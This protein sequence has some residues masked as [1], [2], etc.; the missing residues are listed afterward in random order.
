MAGDVVG[1]VGGG[2]HGALRVDGLEGERDVPLQGYAPAD[3]VDALRQRVC[4]WRCSCEPVR[5]VLPLLSFVQIGVDA[6]AQV[7]V[8]P[9]EVRARDAGT[10]TQSAAATRA[11][12]SRAAQHRTRSPSTHVVSAL[13]GGRSTAYCTPADLRAAFPVAL[14]AIF[15]DSTTTSP[16]AEVQA[17]DCLRAPPDGWQREPPRSRRGRRCCRGRTTPRTRLALEPKPPMSCASF[18]A[19]LSLRLAISRAFCRAASVIL[20]DRRRAAFGALGAHEEHL[21]LGDG[22]EDGVALLLQLRLRHLELALERLELR[23]EAL[24]LLGVAQRR[25]HHRL[26]LL[27]HEL[28]LLRRV[29]VPPH[30]ARLLQPLHLQRLRAVRLLQLGSAACSCSCV[31][32]AACSCATWWPSWS[33]RRRSSG[34]RRRA[35]HPVAPLQLGQVDV[36]RVDV[37][38]VRRDLLDHALA[39][40]HR[41]PQRLQ[42]GVEHLVE[43]PLLHQ[44][45][46][47]ARRAGQPVDLRLPLHQPRRARRRRDVHRHLHRPPAPRPSAAARARAPALGRGAAAAEPPSSA[48]GG[49]L[50]QRGR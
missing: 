31:P 5:L 49:S 3:E 24:R 8:L 25:L 29:A 18:S 9:K 21:L 37:R 45:L 20:L 42:L 35:E 33:I 16:V 38:R 30:L 27:D 47:A 43:L 34:R 13:L 36:R 7:L 12:C 48:A 4:T 26:E 14:K 28:L 32:S 6:R 46:A 15:N 22:G 2:D 17:G 50:P 41:L 44:L 23:L 11:S 39:R 1:A 10:S 40:L 19:S